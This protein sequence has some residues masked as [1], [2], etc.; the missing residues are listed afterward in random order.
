MSAELVKTDGAEE[1]RAAAHDWQRQ[2]KKTD[3]DLALAKIR[4]RKLESFIESQGINPQDIY[5]KVLRTTS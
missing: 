4:I 3:D 5:D 1:Y 2:W